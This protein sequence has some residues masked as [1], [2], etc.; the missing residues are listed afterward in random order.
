MSSDTAQG[1]GDIA[2]RERSES[3]VFREFQ[4]GEGR[5]SIS[6]YRIILESE[7]CSLL[8]AIGTGYGGCL[9]GAGCYFVQLVRGHSP[10]YRAAV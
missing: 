5:Q 8:C 10:L 9:G 3:P 7:E 6:Y 4:S 2:V 1:T